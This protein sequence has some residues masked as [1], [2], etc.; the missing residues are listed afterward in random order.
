MTMMISKFH[1]LI[2][3][4]LLWGVFLVAIVFSF[5]IW[6]MVWPSQSDKAARADAVGTLDGESVGFNE[7]RA[8]DRSIRLSRTLALGRD[9]ASTP[10]TELLLRQLAW[11]RVATLREARKLGITAS[12]QELVSVL[13]ANFSSTNG[14]YN[15]QLYAGFLQNTVAPLGFSVALFEQ[16]LRDEIVIQKLANLIGRQALVTPLE[17]QRTFDTLLDS[18]TV[19]YA[20]LKRDDVAA[21]VTATADDAR[22]LFTANPEA[23]TIPEQRR[24]LYAAYPIAD[25]LAT[26][27]EISEDDI[28][29]YYELHIEDYT[30]QETDD[31]GEPRVTVAELSDVRD[32]IVSALRKATAIDQ[33]EAAANELVFQAIPDRDGT[34]PDFATEAEKAGHPAVT[35]APFSR[36]EQPLPDGGIAFVLTAFELAPNAY[37]RVSSPVLGEENIYIL[38]L[39][40]ILEPR[41]PA[42][43]EVETTAMEAARQKA[44]N[45]ALMAK[46][47]EL[48]QSIADG[49]AAGKTLAAAV[50]GL[51]AEVSVSEPF[52]GLSA[53]SSTNIVEQ[54]LVRAVVGYN[55][56]EITEPVLLPDGLLV[57]Y[58]KQRTAPDEAT[59][60]AYQPEISSAIRARRAQGLFH[61]WQAGLVAPS[62]LTDLQR[63]TDSAD[64][65][66]ESDDTDAEQPA[67]YVNEA[68]LY[69]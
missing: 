55:Q 10:E 43:E 24:I 11:Q 60:D 62:R 52:T 36:H 1:R 56:G 22:D 20:A 37:D 32:D 47:E 39:D 21:H 69:L 18:F 14:I 42:F 12:D 31:E 23:F 63:R 5:V 61:D 3:S 51:G 30:T 13:R 16:H 64:D 35:L 68:E 53:A 49:F 33:A 50:S 38:Y 66:D 29:D 9:V 6:G 45:D 46:G 19:E 27:D 25:Y 17:I 59:F 44:I 58:V 7:F 4:R 65:E 8:A 41:V 48:R 26:D 28:Q 2:Q 15:P 54:A 57:A 34:V 40:K 67:P